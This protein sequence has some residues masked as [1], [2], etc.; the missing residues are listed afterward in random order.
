MGV[1]YDCNGMPAGKILVSNKPERMA[2][3]VQ[4]IDGALKAC[5][6]PKPLTSELKGKC[7]FASNQ[8]FGRIANGPVHAL[9]E[10]EFHSFSPI[11]SEFLREQLVF[12]E[13]HFD[14]FSS[15]NPGCNR[16]N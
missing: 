13:E 7:Q 9:N 6:V 1:V 15:E 2:G 10:H 4:Q 12:A 14:E 16:V 5:I 8:I 3:I 11:V